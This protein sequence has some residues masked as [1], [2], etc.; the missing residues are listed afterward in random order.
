MKI[1]EDREFLKNQR[2]EDRVGSMIGVDRVLAGKEARKKV[3]MERE[4]ARKEK[5]KNE[6]SGE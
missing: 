5:S 6:N 4:K 1:E 2:K 3:R